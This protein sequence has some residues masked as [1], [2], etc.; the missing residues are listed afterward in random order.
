[1]IIIFSSQRIIDYVPLTIEHELNQTF[2]NNIQTLLLS[3]VT[4]QSEIPGRMEELIRE[5]S[6]LGRRRVKLETR[7]TELMNIK[8]KLDDFWSLSNV[9]PPSHFAGSNARP[10]SPA[11]TYHSTTGTTD[12]TDAASVAMSIAARDSSPTLDDHWL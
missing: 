4:Q 10:S 9:P 8:Q 3:S 12:A 2:V 7:R 6:A 5:D 11:S 1:L